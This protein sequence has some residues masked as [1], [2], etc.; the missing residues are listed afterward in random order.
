MALHYVQQLQDLPIVLYCH[1]LSY[2]VETHA[3][4]I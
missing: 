3:E 2:F 4:S 1:E